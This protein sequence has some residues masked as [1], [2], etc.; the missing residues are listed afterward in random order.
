MRNKWLIALASA[1][2]HISVG[3]V[4]AWSVLTKPIVEQ[5]GFSVTATTLIFG[6]SIFFLG[7]G[8]ATLG[9]YV[10]K[11]GAKT[12][13]QYTSILML[14]GYLISAF[15]IHINS[16]VLLY[17]GYGVIIG[18][19]T[20]IF[21]VVP[22]STLVK[23]FPNR[24]G[25]AGS[26]CIA[27]FG[28]SASIMSPIMVYLVSTVGLVG[29]FIILGIIFSI[30]T[31]LSSSYLAP[32]NVEVKQEKISNEV[33]LLPKEVYKTWQ[34][35]ALFTTFNFNIGCGISILALIALML[36][37]DFGLTAIDAAFFV[38]LCSIAN[39]SGRFIW[40]NLSDLTGCPI[41]Y[42]FFALMGAISYSCIALTSNLYIFEIAVLTIISLY[43]GFFSAMPSY[44]RT[45]YSGKYL[46]TIHGSILFAWGLAGAIFPTMLSLC[47]DI[48]GTYTPMIYLFVGLML[49]NFFL[50]WDIRK[51]V[52]AR[53][54][55]YIH[56]VRKS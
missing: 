44:L 53:N 18:G 25:M 23:Y 56:D 36:Q 13:G 41:M 12:V 5:C 37:D 14:I 15:A 22:I 16:I 46:S 8:A 4:Y 39:A 7:C 55:D 51:D 20:G 35:K 50:L 24:V 52:N 47:K 19:V 30:I 42:V 28:L 9:K 17:L 31:F 6:T 10:D 54:G 33:A 34:F 49:I 48:V 1:L 26:I 3:G 29:N 2:I 43:G 21:Y 32:P 45:L 27:S 11:L 38:S 40:A